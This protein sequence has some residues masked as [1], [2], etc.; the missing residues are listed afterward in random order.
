MRALLSLAAALSL[1]ATAA[2]AQP[3]PS[4]PTCAD[5]DAVCAEA[6]PRLDVDVAGVQTS[7]TD[8]REPGETEPF[9]INAGFGD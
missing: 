2:Y 6:T 3:A 4:M 1:T 9:I 5:D 8:A 7:A